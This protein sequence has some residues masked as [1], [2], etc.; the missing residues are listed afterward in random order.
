MD[1][2]YLLGGIILFIVIAAGMGV[3]L[4]YFFKKPKI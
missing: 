1:A 4:W 2:S 3:L